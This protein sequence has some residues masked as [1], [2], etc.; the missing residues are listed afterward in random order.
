MRASLNILNVLDYSPPFYGGVGAHLNALGNEAG[1]RGYRL[2]LAFPRERDWFEDASRHASSVSVISSIRDPFRRGFAASLREMIRTERIDVVHLHFSFALAV[3]CAL[4]RCGVPIVYHWHNPPRALLRN[5]DAWISDNRASDVGKT[6]GRV[7]DRLSRSASGIFARVG[8]VAVKR[9]IVISREIEALLAQH[10]WTRRGKI[11]YL[12]NAL[13]QIPERPADFRSSPSPFVLGS[14]ANFRRQKDHVTLLRAF[15]RCVQAEPD[16]RLELVGDGE[17]RP[18]IEELARELGIESFVRFLGHVEDPDEAYRRT[19]AF[20]LSTHYEG[21]GLVILEAMGHGLPIMATDLPSIRET[22]KEPGQALLFPPGDSS[23]LAESILRL[24]RDS[25]LRENLARRS[26][27]AAL[28]ALTPDGWAR[29]V[30]TVY[31][32]VVQ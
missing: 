25:S 22:L 27:A 30:V 12:P 26:R 24:V 13:P 5:S 18:R 16:L 6:A 15:A 31:E 1:A 21:Q 4:G 17:T 3:A 28:D 9:H 11:V 20:A 8:D 29:Q 19:D 2:H 7:K 14:V 23:A 10:L 32:S